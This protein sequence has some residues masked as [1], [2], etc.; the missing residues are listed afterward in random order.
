MDGLS[1]E[2]ALRQS[3]PCEPHLSSEEK[4]RLP[5]RREEKLIFFLFLSRGWGLTP[6]YPQK[7]KKERR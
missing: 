5:F 6:P 3:I 7:T 4:T 1:E 2:F